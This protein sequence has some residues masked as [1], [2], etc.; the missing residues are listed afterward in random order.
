MESA[1]TNYLH[2]NDLPDDVTFEGDLAVDTEAMGLNNLRDR[3]CVIQISDGNG[4]AHLVQFEKGNYDAP[5]VKALIADPSRVK[6]F[7]F[8]RFDLAIM[9]HYLGVMAEPVYCTKIASKLCRTYTDRHGFKDVCRELIEVDVSKMQ[10]SSNWGAD[11]LTQAQIDYAAADV[12]YLHRL[13]EELNK[14]LMKEGR[15]ELAEETFKCLP[16][17]AKLDLA[18][19]GETDIFSHS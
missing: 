1:I 2:K 8:A 7:H 17:R 13:R 6:M 14:R 18:G 19:W 15:M 9:Q 12:L 5:N 11:E 4:D 3:L 10:Q 16:V